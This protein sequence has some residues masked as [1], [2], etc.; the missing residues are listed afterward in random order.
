M[1][2]LLRLFCFM[3]IP[4]PSKRTNIYHDFSFIQIITTVDEDFFCGIPFFLP[5]E[6]FG[7]EDA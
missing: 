7:G 4:S 5:A 2:P 3:D 1:M 6:F